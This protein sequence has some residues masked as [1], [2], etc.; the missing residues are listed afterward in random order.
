MA[1][2]VAF[3]FVG[4]RGKEDCYWDSPP[5]LK[6]IPINIKIFRQKNTFPEDVKFMVPVCLNMRAKSGRS[7]LST[8]QLLYPDYFCCKTNLRILSS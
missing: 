7:N 2:N 8:S 4:G 6:K 3:F 5:P 1:T